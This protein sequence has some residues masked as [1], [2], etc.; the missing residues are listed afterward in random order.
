MLSILRSMGMTTATAEATERAP[1]ARRLQPPAQ[2]FDLLGSQA[3]VWL[4][5]LDPGT[6]LLDVY[7]DLTPLLGGHP[8]T[9]Q[10]LTTYVHP[11]D[12]PGLQ[13][14]LAGSFETGAPGQ[15]ECR[16]RGSAEEW[17]HFHVSYCADLNQAGGF[18]LHG[19]SRD[20]TLLAQARLAAHEAIRQARLAESLSGLGYW[21]YDLVT[22]AFTWSNQ[23]YA[24]YGFDPGDDP[25][26][27][28]A[29]PDSCHPDDR[30]RVRQH[31]EKYRGREAPALACRIVRTDGE[32][33]HLLAR[34]TIE[35]DETGTPIARFGVIQDVTEIKKAEGAARESEQ[36]Y[37]FIAEHASDMIVRLSPMGELRFVSPGSKRV[38]GY[39]PAEL[40]AMTA[41]NMT[42]PDDL[43]TVVE[44]FTKLVE[45]GP[46]H[47]SE[48]LRYRAKHKDGSWVWIESNPS[49]IFDESTGE[50]IES[51]DIIRNINQAKAVE[52]ELERA[53]AKA[54]AAAAAKS[55]FL[56]NMSHELRTPLTCITG[57]SR[58][59][60]DQ[61]GLPEQARGHI[62]RIR[63]ASDALLAVINDVL[64]FSKVE[65][66]QLELEELPLSVERLVE[67]A[68]GLLAVQAAAK[69]VSLKVRLDPLT[70]ALVT[71]DVAR[72]RQV[73][74]NLLSNALK[75]TSRG[76]VTVATRYRPKNARLCFKV[77]DTGTGIPPEALGN[78]FERFS[79]A[80]V[81]INRTHGGT[82]LG[83]AISKG[84]VELMGGEIGVDTKPGAG[85]TFWFD[86]P[87]TPA[88]QEANA[89]DASEGISDLALPRLRL[90]VVDDTAVNRELVRLMLEPL[91][92]VIEE[93]GG[94]AEG[95]QAA[96]RSPFDLILM[97]VRM[98][99]VDGLEA[100]RIIR[101]TS[102][103][104]SGTPILALT[105][106][107]QAE[108][109]TACRLAGM[110]D[111]L[112]KPINPTQLITRILHWAAQSD[113]LNAQALA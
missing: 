64:E 100:T 102:T 19:V 56:A 67:D 98:P 45:G 10:E 82:G 73:L 58:L 85:S 44:H 34:N 107:V 88:G 48:P 91:G 113:E 70:P 74:L 32:V 101:G 2:F 16:L 47:V 52:A 27:L 13:S 39:E 109:A 69:G 65:A 95:V 92:F 21:R 87:A 99:G 50:P 62:K 9:L 53:R 29:M 72:L 5:S 108:N 35:R 1:E 84:I 78:L 61:T 28:E 83:L 54:E 111:V 42:H 40:L 49:V 105:A 80:E 25:P 8:R 23:M 26:P 36:R 55:T 112:A 77:I 66:G 76:S 14:Q 11:E 30:E 22:K 38:F 43:P 75:F 60:E 110:N 68:A 104:N 96:M 17:T 93:A 90:L 3:G 7:S 71:G 33:R 46:G 18:T 37:R 20:V 81:S 63:N 106:D 86:V 59:L 89:E 15:F 79:Q 31:Q 51:I 6:D 24:I 57:F 12:L 97:D 4:W 103:V 94:G 41:P